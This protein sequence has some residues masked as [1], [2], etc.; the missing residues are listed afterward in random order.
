M[1][2]IEVKEDKLN[3]LELSDLGISL[4]AIADKI[5]ILVDGYKSGYECKEC[6]GTGRVPSPVIAGSMRDCDECKGKG[7]TIH[8]PDTAKS[9]PSTGVVVSMGPLCTKSSVQIGTRVVYGVHVGTPIPI[10]GNIKLRIMRE[11]EP[12]CRIFGSDIGDKEI[13]DYNQGDVNL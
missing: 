5:I 7:V 10:K 8:I 13:L 6:K 11:H 4:E 9:M 2:D 1:N 3:V 12:L